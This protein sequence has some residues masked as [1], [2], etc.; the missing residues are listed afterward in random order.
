MLSVA[1]SAPCSTVV[2]SSSS[3]QSLTYSTLEDV[4]DYGGRRGGGRGGSGW[5]SSGVDKVTGEGGGG[6][7][8]GAD[9]AM[10]DRRKWQLLSGQLPSESC[11]WQHPEESTV[12]HGLPREPQ[13]QPCQPDHVAAREEGLAAA[14]SQ[15]AGSV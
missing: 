14:A 1:L 12:G 5:G 9:K 3:P 7:G 8:E 4:S 10:A 15:S 2:V 13:H 6:G 11:W